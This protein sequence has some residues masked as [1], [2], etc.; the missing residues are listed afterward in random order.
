MD[1]LPAPTDWQ[2]PAVP[3][4][5]QRRIYKPEDFFAIPK[6]E[7]YHSLEDLIYRGL[8]T[9][10]H[11]ARS[12][13][14]QFIQ[15]WLFFALL[16]RVLG[17]PIHFKSL[18]I[19][20]PN[21]RLTTKGLAGLVSEWAER[22][23]QTTNRT[24]AESVSALKNDYVQA[25]MALEFARRF[26]WKHIAN[27]PF[28]DDDYNANT[29]PWRGNFDR[30]HGNGNLHGM[31]D[32]AVTLS[33]ASVGE[34]L[35]EELWARLPPRQKDRVE[36]WK[37]PEDEERNWGYSL[38]CREQMQK[39]GWCKPEIRR[40]EGIMFHVNNIY[41][42]CS[43]GQRETEH[44]VRCCTD[45]VCN[46]DSAKTLPLQE[47]HFHKQAYCESPA[48]T[49]DEGELVAIIGNGHIPLVRWTNHGK[50]VCKGFDLDIESPL[51]FG[52]VSHSWSENIL[53]CGEDS[54]G[55]N[56]RCMI[57]C[58]L[59]RLR[60]TFANILSL[61]PGDG[62]PW[63]WVDVLCLPRDWDRK[64]TLLN[65]LNTIYRKATAVLIW[66]R[67]LLK[68]DKPAK[69]DYIEMNVRL[70]T[71]HWSRRLWTVPEAV[72]GKHLYVAFKKGYLELDK[73]NSASKAAMLDVRHPH[74]FVWKSGRPL[75]PSI[76]HIRSHIHERGKEFPVQR[77]WQALQFREATVKEDET[78]VLASILGLNVCR[79]LNIKTP[80]EVYTGT[81]APTIESVASA[82]MIEFLKAVDET[83]GLGIPSGLVF[84]PRPKL[85]TQQYGWAPK[86]WMQRQLHTYPLFRP[87]K[88]TGYMMPYGLHVEFPGL[89]LHCPNPV[90]KK[91][92]F[93]I[94]VSQ[95][96]HKWFKVWIDDA[97]SNV[98]ELKKRLQPS[99]EH[100]IILNAEKTRERWEVGLFVKR[101]GTL[102]CGDVW[103]VETIC[104]V[105]VRLETNNDELMR[106]R[107][108]F[109][110]D[111]KQMYFGERVDSQRW[112][113]EEF[114]PDATS[115]EPEC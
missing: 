53:N 12:Q 2:H 68:R 56:N 17:T 79:F 14:N 15:S 26:C 94:P 10:K 1:H 33:I 5:A 100:C 87:L 27:R 106:L 77:A 57:Q 39:H 21:P 20:G 19:E 44:T 70:D 97:G 104:R 46:V 90:I 60:D 32:K 11:T 64:V 40:L 52:A 29:G 45:W 99:D 51:Q 93:W 72:L 89:I 30:K 114:S 67:N 7:G 4:Y 18:V 110:E 76:R 98:E 3:F 101:K 38:W 42:A 25:S 37:Q 81:A 63:F 36:F 48:Q 59:G 43:M 34:I 49:V 112:C 80:T 41:Y 84:L 66:D 74:H 22:W 91:K 9:K 103:R 55:R 115:S 96:L 6:S 107:T 50:L 31:F 16:A 69:E 88:K 54:A 82:R 62:E 109:H 86:T 111:I 58:Q 8:D 24:D 105:W 95:T 13:V 75:D 61:N 108:E 78:I 47:L 35:Q 83:P 65:K 92:I 85:E 102:A 73:V 113:V 71:G 28:E 23:K